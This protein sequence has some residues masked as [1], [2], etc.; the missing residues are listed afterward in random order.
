MVDVED[1]QFADG[2]IALQYGFGVVKFR[3]VM[4]RGL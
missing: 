3:N 1:E 4:I 2:P